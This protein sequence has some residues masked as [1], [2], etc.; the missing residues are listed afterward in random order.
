MK[1]KRRSTVVRCPI[2]MRT[3]NVARTRRALDSV[4]ELLDRLESGIGWALD[5]E[6]KVFA[7]RMRTARNAIDDADLLLFKAYPPK[8]RKL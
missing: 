7:A 1:R 5:F 2:I 6:C 4:L 8:R 3:P